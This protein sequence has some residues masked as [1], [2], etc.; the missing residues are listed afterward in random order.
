MRMRRLVM[1]RWGLATLGLAVAA[2]LGGCGFQLRGS[3]TMAFRT[4]QL[5]GFA[6]N[7][8]LANEL[9]RALQA[10]GV[11]VVESTLAAAQA[12]S[13]ATVPSSHIVIEGLGNKQG[14]VAST[15]TAYGQVRN[16][17]LSNTLR[18][19]VKRGDGSVLLPPTNVSL[20]RDM[21]YNETD[22]LAKQEESKSL[23]LAMQ[24][25]IVGQVM[26][27]LAAIR[28]D[29][30]PSPPVPA[31]PPAPVTLSEWEAAREAARQARSTAAD[32]ASAAPADPA[33][34]PR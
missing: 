23:L 19:Q 6:G 7:S 15:T 13:S 1:H 25:D 34:A 11:D 17:S 16:F 31:K 27:R 2:S 26:R 18:F 33:S 22:A 4:A 5:S 14:T 21:S 10:S 9:A 12:A 30:L 8:T 28:A 29:Q 20:S 3:E 24:S 32:A